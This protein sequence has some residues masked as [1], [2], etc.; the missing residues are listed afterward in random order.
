MEIPSL[1]ALI[2]SQKVGPSPISP[3][4]VS[5]KKFPS[6]PSHPT[7][8]S[9]SN[10]YS[11]SFVK[12]DYLLCS[13][14][15][16]CPKVFYFGGMCLE[17]GSID[18]AGRKSLISLAQSHALKEIRCGKQTTIV[19][20]LRTGRSQEGGLKLL[21]FI[22]MCMGLGVVLDFPPSKGLFRIAVLIF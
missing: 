16:K 2:A 14:T 6:T 11:N 10:H 21:C 19:H 3:H 20:T 13:K 22:L 8:V 18:L 9:S 1:I 15:K 5:P 12:L 4:C 17:K 7:K